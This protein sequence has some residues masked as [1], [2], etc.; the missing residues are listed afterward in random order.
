V[1]TSSVSISVSNG[2]GKKHRIGIIGALP[3]EVAEI[4]SKMES[5][6]ERKHGL[7]TFIIGKF[8]GKDIVLARSGVGVVYAGS[9]ATIMVETYAATSII[10]TG[11]AGGI[12]E[13][14][15]IGDIIV[16]KDLINYEMN[17]K[18]F[19]LAWNPDYRHKL[20]EFPFMNG[21]RELTCDPTLVKLAM[22]APLGESKLNP[23]RVIGRVVTGSEFVTNTRKKELASLWKEL[24]DPD[25]VE[26]EG[27]AVSQ[28]AH[29][30]KIPFLILRSLSDTLEGDANEDFNAFATQVA[31]LLIPIVE[32]VIHK[33]E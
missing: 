9:V 1:S 11:V 2:T 23:R 5:F 12:K 4:E 7:F 26:M 19:I 24:G 30:Y 32:Y 8:G 27:A 16:A 25:A 31:E 33:L 21:L 29:S 15:K 10:F 22:E 28:V 17:C 6:E 20:G 14:G 13:G 18:N 3:Q